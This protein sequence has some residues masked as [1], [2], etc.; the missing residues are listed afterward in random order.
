MTQIND[1]YSEGT[2][3]FKRKQPKK[4]RI[5]AGAVDGSNDAT[6]PSTRK[7]KDGTGTSIDSQTKQKVIK[8]TVPRFN[9]GEITLNCEPNGS[10][11]VAGQAGGVNAVGRQTDMVVPFLEPL[12][13]VTNR[14]QV[15][16]AWLVGMGQVSHVCGRSSAFVQARKFNSSAV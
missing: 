13:R 1:S 12:I 6:L 5:P 3:G 9:K 4:P 14:N 16:V 7:R 8:S 11:S 10:G 2:S 15:L